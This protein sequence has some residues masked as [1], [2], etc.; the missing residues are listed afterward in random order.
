MAFGYWC[1]V[2]NSFSEKGM[3]TAEIQYVY[4]LVSTNVDHDTPLNSFEML[5]NLE[6]A[7]IGRLQVCDGNENFSQTWVITKPVHVFHTSF[8]VSEWK[9]LVLFSSIIIIYFW[10]DKN[11]LQTATYVSTT[12]FVTSYVWA[13]VTASDFCHQ[14]K[15][16][17]S[18]LA[19]FL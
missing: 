3:G 10:H 4:W 9:K 7:I 8:H 5:L 1:P 13:F 18:S 11:L 17:Q 16:I 15:K 14:D 6:V 19:L 12:A 2:L